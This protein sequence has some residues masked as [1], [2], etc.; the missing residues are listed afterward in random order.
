MEV[1]E[2]V[3]GL[4]R[5]EGLA[6]VVVTHHVNLAA[7]FVQRLLVLDRGAARALGTPTAVLT[8]ETVEGVFQWPVDVQSWQGIPQIIPKRRLEAQR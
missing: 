8:P 1:F 3:S 7:R 5:E 2:L 6:G 4:V